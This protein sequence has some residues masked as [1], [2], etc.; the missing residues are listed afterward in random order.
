MKRWLRKAKKI[1]FFKESVNWLIQQTLVEFHSTPEDIERYV[2]TPENKETL[3]NSNQFVKLNS[4]FFAKICLDEKQYE[5]YYQ[6]LERVLL[7]LLPSHNSKVISD[8]A[9]FM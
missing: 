8:F 4:G 6:V 1:L 5:A 3:L 7:K 2:S 9:P